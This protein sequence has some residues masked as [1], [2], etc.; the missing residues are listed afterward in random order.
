MQSAL[1]VVQLD[2]DVATHISVVRDG[3]RRLSASQ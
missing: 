2:V 3:F 1:D